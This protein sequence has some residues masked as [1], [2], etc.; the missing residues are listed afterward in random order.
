MCCAVW[1]LLTTT[2]LTPA[3][4][5]PTPCLPSL[6]LRSAPL[7]SLFSTI[8]LSAALEARKSGALDAIEALLGCP[9]NLFE[10]VGWAWI[11]SV[12]T[13]LLSCPLNLFEMVGWARICSVFAG[14][15]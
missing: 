7:L 8:R 13:L 2:T 9:L 6:P 15:C 5:D 14:C 1:T 3:N 12:L 4:P 10:M 11:C